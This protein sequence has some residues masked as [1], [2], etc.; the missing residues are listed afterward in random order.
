MAPLP[1]HPPARGAAFP[2]ITPERHWTIRRARVVNGRQVSG[3][4]LLVFGLILG[5]TG[6]IVW[7]VASICPNSVESVCISTIQAAAVIAIVISAAMSI[8][9]IVLLAIG[10]RRNPVRPD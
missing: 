1:E 2:F 3:I 9:G 4:A 10:G 5:A 8:A 7:S 6:F